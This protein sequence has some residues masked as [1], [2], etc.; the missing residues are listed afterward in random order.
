MTDTLTLASAPHQAARSGMPVAL[1][2][3]SR[4][5]CSPATRSN[6]EQKANAN[7]HLIDDIGLTRHEGEA[8]IAKPL[9]GHTAAGG[10]V[11]LL[12]R[13][14]T[15]ATQWRTWRGSR[16]TRG[17]IDDLSEG[18][19]RELGISRVAQRERWLDGRETQFATD[20]FYRIGPDV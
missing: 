2:E 5:H 16:A 4:R 18:E 9:A 8:G 6:R 10:V 12:G 20:Y 7:P 11:R 19:L 1:A 13:L 17:E 15:L 14:G 3:G